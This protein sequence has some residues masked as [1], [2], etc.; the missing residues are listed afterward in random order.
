MADYILESRVWLA[1]A[2]PRSTRF[3][4]PL[5]PTLSDLPLGFDACFGAGFGAG[6]VVLT[7]GT[8]PASEVCSA[9]QRYPT[10]GSVTMRSGAWASSPSFFRRARTYVR[11]Y[12]VSVP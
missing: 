2:R 5:S 3:A 11:R 4:P 1:R 8:Y 7:W 9:T 6:S 12:V 10:P